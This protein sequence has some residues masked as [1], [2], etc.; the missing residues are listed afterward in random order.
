VGFA[1]ILL[2][3]SGLIELEVGMEEVFQQHYRQASIHP[4]SQRS[5]FIAA[6]ITGQRWWVESAS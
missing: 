1:E 2:S 3:I 5:Y 4:F 6:S